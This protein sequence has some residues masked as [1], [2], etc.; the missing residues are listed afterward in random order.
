[1][2]SCLFSGFAG[3]GEHRGSHRHARLLH[4]APPVSTRTEQTTGRSVLQPRRTEDRRYTTGWSQLHALPTFI[5][6]IHTPYPIFLRLLLR[7]P[8]Y[9]PVIPVC[10]VQLSD[11]RARHSLCGDCHFPPSCRLPFQ[12]WPSACTISSL[13]VRILSHRILYSSSSLFITSPPNRVL[14]I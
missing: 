14:N 3:D 8:C 10:M 13:P 7:R 11:R 9:W 6:L 5:P 12:R 2:F 4:N 1:M